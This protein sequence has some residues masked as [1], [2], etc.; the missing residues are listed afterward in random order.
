MRGHTYWGHFW[1]RAIEHLLHKHR[2]VVVDVIHLDDEF[3]GAFQGPVVCSVND[4]GCQLILCLLLPVQP[5]KGIDVPAGLL[6]LEDGIGIFTLD[7][8]L[9]VA[10]PDAGCDLEGKSNSGR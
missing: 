9:G 8:V 3:G 5:L 2:S 1:D 4:E 7:D 6:H 10:V